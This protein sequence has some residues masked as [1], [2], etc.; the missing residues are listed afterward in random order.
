MSNT[1]LSKC[2][3]SILLRGL[4]Y[5]PTPQSNSIQLTCDLKTFAHKLRL[6]EYFDDHNVMPIDQKNESLVQGKSMF[7]PPRNRNK[8]LETHISFIHNIDIAN[9]KSNKKSNFS[10]KEWRELRNLMNQPNIVIKEAGKGGA[11]AVLS[12]HHYRA[13]IYEHLS[14]QNTYQKLDKNLDPTIMRKLNKLLNK[15]KRSFIV[16]EFKYLT[17]ADYNTSN[18]YGLPKIQKSQLITNAIKEKNSEVVSINKPQDLKV[19]PI[20]GGPKCPTRKLSELIDALLKPFLKHVKSCIRDSI[21]FL[22]KCDR[23]TNGNTVTATFDVVGLYTNIPHTF[24]IEAVRYFLLKYKEHINPRFNIPFILESVDFILKSNT[25]VFDNEYFLQLQGTAMGTVFAPNIMVAMQDLN[26][27][28]GIR[29]R[30]FLNT[31]FSLSSTF[32][33]CS[34]T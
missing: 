10:P 31:E 30:S 25:C 14:N 19:R 9:E 33:T 12:K 1:T 3:T 29:N 4:K 2:Q 22:K 23:N 20:V 32:L 16:K 7:Y 34:Y 18:F 8:E 11:V 28:K 5:T 26:T 13:M 27:Q 24:G 6:T 15:H 17:E 21:N